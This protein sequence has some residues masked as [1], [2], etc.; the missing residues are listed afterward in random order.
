MLILAVVIAVTGA[1]A[2][3]IKADPSLLPMTPATVKAIFAVLGV[4]IIVEATLLTTAA[5]F[6]IFEGLLMLSDASAWRNP[7]VPR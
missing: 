7:N 3:T 1:L 5:G 6:G 4:S 2:F